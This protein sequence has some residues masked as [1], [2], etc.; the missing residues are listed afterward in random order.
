MKFSWIFILLLP[1]I[2]LSQYSSSDNWLL[3]FAG[4]NGPSGKVYCIIKDSQGNI[5]AGGN[6]L[7]AGGVSAKYIAMWDGASWHDVGAGVN[8][9]VYALALD[10]NGN[11]YVGGE[12]TV[13]DDLTVNRIA[14]W[15]GTNWHSMSGGMNNTVYSI[16]I[17]DNGVVYA[18][19]KFTLAGTTNVN[20][21][22][23]W[24]GA[25]WLPVG[26]GFNNYVYVLKFDSSGNNLYAGG[27]FTSSST[28][29]MN[30]IAKWDNIS[31]QPLGNGVN[32]TVRTIEFDN[33]SNVYIGGAFD[34]SGSVQLNHIGCWNGSS[35]LQM[36]NG[37]NDDVK[38]LLY[39][40]NNLY[41]GGNFTTINNYS[42]SYLAKWNGVDFYSVSD[43]NR[44][45]LTLLSDGSNIIA[46]GSFTLIDNIPVSYIGIYDGVSFNS[47]GTINNGLNDTGYTV[48]Y[49]SVNNV[50]YIGGAFTSAGG[51]VVN[52]IVKW[53]GSDF[54]TIG[55][56]FNGTVRTICVDEFGN[57]YVGGSF[58]KS[59][60]VTVNYIAKWNGSIWES[61]GT[62]MNDE[63]YSVYIDINGNL[64]A[65]G[66]FTNSGGVPTNYLSKWVGSNWSSFGNFD[67]F[68]NSIC[69]DKSG[70]I[71]VGGDFSIVDGTIVNHIAKYNGSSW[72]GLGS[73]LNNSVL[74]MVVDTNNY[75]YV[76]G[77]FTSNGTISLK[78]IAKWNG[79]SWLNVG[80]G[81]NG[82]V[83]TLD[84]D[85]NNYLYAGGAF[86]NMGGL[87]TN[88]IAKWNG[89]QWEEITSGL[90]NNV[91]AIDVSD[92][93]RFFVTGD[94]T[95]ANGHSSAFFAQYKFYPYIEIYG[96]NIQIL[97]NDSI[98]SP[99]DNTFFGNIR[100]CD[101]N[102]TKEFLIYN[103]GNWPLY[104]DSLTI[105]GADSLLY[106]VQ[107]LSTIISVGDSLSFNINFGPADVGMKNAEV[108]VTSDSKTNSIYSYSISTNSFDTLIPL[109]QIPQF[110]NIFFDSL[111]TAV[112]LNKDAVLSATDNCS[113]TDT[114][115][116]K[117][118]FDCTA[119]YTLIDTISVS[120]KDINNNT[121]NDSLIII[122]NDTIV[123]KLEVIP[124]YDVF[125]DSNG[126]AF[127]K[128][129]DVVISAYDNCIADTLLSIDTLDCSYLDSV[130]QLTVN[131]LDAFG[132]S[133]IKT[134]NLSII[135]TIKPQ[136]LLTDTTIAIN[137][138]GY[139]VLTDTAFI[140]YAIDNCTVQ[141]IQFSKDTLYCS[142]IGVNSII[143]SSTDYSGNVSN[144]ILNINLIDTLPPQFV[145]YDTTIYLN[146]NGEFNLSDIVLVDSINEN[147]QIQ[148]TIFIPT[149][150]N[151]SNIG[152]NNVIVQ[153][154][155]INNN[156]SSKTIKINVVD[157]VP[158][159]PVID[160]L[161]DINA[162][163]STSVN[164][165]AAIDNCGQVIY[166]ETKD[167]LYY[168]MQGVYFINWQYFDSYN[169]VTN[170][171]Q[172]VVINDNTPPVPHV[173][174]LQDIVSDCNYSIT[175]I[176]TASD[177]C[178]GE[179]IATTNDPMYYNFP[180]Q[181]VVTWN[182]LDDNNNNTQQFQIYDII[183]D[184]PVVL[185]KNITIMLDVE[186]NA[187]I[188]PQD[189]DNGSYDDCEIISMAIDKENF[190]INDV[191]DNYVT[192]TVIDNVNNISSESAIVTV[193][194]YPE[195]Q[196]PN[197]IS[198]NGDGVNDT[199]N[200]TGI[201][202]LI[203]YKLYIY[204]Q[205]NNLIYQSDQYMNNWDGT[206]NGKVLPD[207]TYYYLFTNN[208]KKISG[209]ITLIK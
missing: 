200:I 58:T 105:V 87:N 195:L 37:A 209:Y 133:D 122:F 66:K 184:A 126:I 53:D 162:Q 124:N 48:A 171:I 194:K 141:N 19:G 65:G 10:N 27:S 22:A 106:N 63:V 46:G 156:L 79:T 44:E 202:H 129:Y 103:A 4:V 148:D 118:V 108:V 130:F 185:T 16:A 13:A 164:L 167:T 131:L 38:T 40:N 163:C 6:F 74:S 43:L 92:D 137:E 34:Y 28:I 29:S 123:P 83:F 101:T 85:R 172:R 52:Q 128:P 112:I 134:L 177:N 191:G 183:N 117:Y 78:Y 70:N 8:G 67:G 135:D 155:D 15:D 54:S 149:L 55:N 21:I 198:P 174:N 57:I 186:G 158:P 192:L 7:T 207:G 49:D 181:Y 146:E 154:I 196:I 95:L 144:N 12:F 104:I 132:N 107:P 75:L 169:N 24:N 31:W 109:V 20:Y 136:F 182:Y 170:Q 187:S 71:Y 61:L 36:G 190:N 98:V 115:L 3:D 60:S 168:D 47:I 18:G 32:N 159:V 91:R 143:V 173:T 204:N 26:T 166:G 14:V 72:L 119:S 193:E 113:I 2:T 45:V 73:G 23:K 99:D 9:P 142:D 88:Y 139:T 102:V 33:S 110:I 147:C 100:A 94:F 17:D 76:G 68:V 56:G 42:I 208:Q 188:T 90:N 59:G 197:F 96:N 93:G 77:Q 41:I 81:A 97:N 205:S 140:K 11:L 206:Y 84:I 145:A 39:Y 151:C 50:V 62:G 179:I 176:P 150:L 125:L 153:L 189:I 178:S 199:W 69:G 89:N 86:T 161:P 160:P 111:G 152:E 120:V 30:R 114:I 116:S 138:F 175:E 121:S 201:D 157:T 5:Y 1:I 180:G 35:W 82:Y 64:Y 127:L 165:P 25:N 203:G 51:N 80:S